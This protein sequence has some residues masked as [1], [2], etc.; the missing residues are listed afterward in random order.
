M[1]RDAAASS[2][3]DRRPAVIRPFMASSITAGDYLFTRAWVHGDHFETA[4]DGA[5]T[6]ASEE[7][8]WHDALETQAMFET[9]RL[10][11]KDFVLMEWVPRSPGRYHSAA[12]RQARSGA[13]EHMLQVTTIADREGGSVLYDPVGKSAMITGGLGCLRLA[14]KTLGGSEVKL[15]SASSSG[16]AHGGI[17]VAVRAGDYATLGARIAERGGARCSLTGEL[18]YWNA[19][20]Y[21]PFGAEV[22][23]P[24]LY[25]LVDDL[26]IGADKLP[27]LDATPAIVFSSQ[28]GGP[29]GA[30]DFYGNFYAYTHID[31]ADAEAVPRCVRWLQDNY[32]EAR[33]SGRVLTDFDETTPRFP[34]TACAL[35]DVLDPA[36]SLAEVAAPLIEENLVVPQLAQLYV[37]TLNVERWEATMSNFSITGDGN[38][39]GN[40]NQVVTTIHRGLDREGLRELGE[41]FAL[42]RGEIIQLDDVPDKVKNQAARAL[43]DAEEEAADENPDQEVV[44]GSLRRAKDVLEA[45]GETY[46][47][48]KAWGQRFLELGKALAVAIPAMAHYLPML[49]V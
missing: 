32:V 25:L 7:D 45:A 28:G 37:Q 12:G 5:A 34:A 27:N 23:I 29:E 18:R 2:A 21:L 24:R 49:F 11:L 10:V 6:Y 38:V 9:R 13:A 41:A 43:E 4:D 15:L 1:G 20:K 48:S 14:M 31:P 8:F 39:V 30:G 40:N 44:I 42:L 17:V 36:R 16:L 35:R 26:D 3:T 19:D 47:S 46:D 22:G 33:Y